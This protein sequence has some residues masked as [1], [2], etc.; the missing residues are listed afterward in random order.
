MSATQAHGEVASACGSLF[1]AIAGVLGVG[2]VGTYGV[3]DL[4]HGC[5]SNR[6]QKFQILIVRKGTPSC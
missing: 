2:V 5:L 4:G 1:A 3:Y 6:P